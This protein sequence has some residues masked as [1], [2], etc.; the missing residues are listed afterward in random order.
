ML[1]KKKRTAKKT[2]KKR[3]S[4]NKMGNISTISVV[5]SLPPI[6]L[7]PF[8]RNQIDFRVNKPT[9]LCVC[10]PLLFFTGIL[11]F[12]CLT[13]NGFLLNSLRKAIC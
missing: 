4:P 12:I 6:S 10:S 5:S 8:L 3:R 13:R 11:Y 2:K 7:S 9:C 1:L